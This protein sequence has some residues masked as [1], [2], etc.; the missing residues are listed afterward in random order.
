MSEEVP[1]EPPKEGPKLQEQVEKLIGNVFDELPHSGGRSRKYPIQED[2]IATHALLAGLTDPGTRV[3]P[4]VEIQ[5][6]SH[7]NLDKTLTETPTGL[8]II[9]PSRDDATV[10]WPKYNIGTYSINT[11]PKAPPGEKIHRQIPIVLG[12]DE[13]G[14]PNNTKYDERQITAQERHDLEQL[15]R[16]FGDE[17]DLQKAILNLSIGGHVS[18][19]CEHSITDPDGNRDRF[20]LLRVSEKGEPIDTRLSVSRKTQTTQDGKQVSN[21]ASE[22][23]KFDTNGLTS[24]THNLDGEEP[25]E[26]DFTKDPSQ[27]DFYTQNAATALTDILSKKDT[28]IAHQPPPFP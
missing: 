6:Q 1:F 21:Y 13:S 16:D 23:W 24:Y 8:D 2:A 25:F 17:P 10:F 4:N 9:D 27:K 12:R 5:F 19:F 7:Y 11:A 26:V 20:T 22:Q 3:P 14:S 28:F 15:T 18:Q